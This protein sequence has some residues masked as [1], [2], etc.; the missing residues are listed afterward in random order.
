MGGWVELYPCFFLIFG[1]FLTLQSPL[2]CNDYPS[3]NTRAS[4]VNPTDGLAATRYVVNEPISSSDCH[5]TMT[6]SREPCMCRHTL[7]VT[8]TGANEYALIHCIRSYSYKSRN[9]FLHA[10]PMAWAILFES[11]TTILAT[12]QHNWQCISWLYIDSTK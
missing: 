10:Q 12:V 1:I 7:L 9:N 6:R 8:R 2:C 3:V 11:R 5:R 4:R